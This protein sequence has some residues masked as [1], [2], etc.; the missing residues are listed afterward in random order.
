MS[1]TSDPS[2]GEEATDPADLRKRGDKAEAKAAE[3]AAEL[4]SVK[5]ELAL[6][7]AGVPSQGTGALFRKAYDGELTAE[8]IQASMAE[9]GIE[10]PSTAPASAPAP[11]GAGVVNTIAG[12]MAA[13]QP[14]QQTNDNAQHL[15][16]VLQAES[17]AEVERV[18]DRVGL[19]YDSEDAGGQLLGSFPD[20]LRP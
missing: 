18:L 20:E 17:Q 5:R 9:Y 19:L 2:T 12:G 11:E 4:E 6:T 13:E 14:V 8:A 15:E 16:A 3:L 1:D 10:A 7:N